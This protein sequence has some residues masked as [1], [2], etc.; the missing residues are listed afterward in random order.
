MKNFIKSDSGDTIIATIS[1]LA[2]GQ[3]FHTHFAIQFNMMKDVLFIIKYKTSI[4]LIRS[5]LNYSLYPK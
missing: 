3:S 5:V 2:S 4:S 1:A